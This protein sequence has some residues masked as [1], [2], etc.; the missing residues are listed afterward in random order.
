MAHRGLGW[1]KIFCALWMVAALGADEEWNSSRSISG[2]LCKP[3]WYCN[4][5]MEP[6]GTLEPNVNIGM[7]NFLNIHM[8]M[9]PQDAEVLPSKSVSSANFRESRNTVMY[10]DICAWLKIWFA[11]CSCWGSS[12]CSFMMSHACR[13]PRLFSHRCSN[14]NNLVSGCFSLLKLCSARRLVAL[15]F[16]LPRLA[17]NDRLKNI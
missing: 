13:M 4:S 11:H 14:H 10:T 16:F 2:R 1:F 17:P 8:S 3:R 12:Y 9:L 5:C 15:C 7:A 6:V